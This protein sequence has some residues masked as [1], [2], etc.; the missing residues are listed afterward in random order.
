MKRNNLSDTSVLPVTPSR[1]SDEVWQ[2][3]PEGHGT[4]KTPV[5]V[6]LGDQGRRQTNGSYIGLYEESVEP[7]NKGTQDDRITVSLMG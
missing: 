5:Q 1:P 6:R 4:P 2:F 3:V 7:G